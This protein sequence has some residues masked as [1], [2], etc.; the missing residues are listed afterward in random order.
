MK[1]WKLATGSM[2]PSALQSAPVK[3]S[4]PAHLPAPSRGLPYSQALDIASRPSVT[5]ASTNWMSLPSP[6]PTGFCAALPLTITSFQTN[7]E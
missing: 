3:P 4:D 7:S 2:S 5:A 1:G 6:W